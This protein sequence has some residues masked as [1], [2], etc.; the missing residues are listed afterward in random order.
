MKR[1]LTQHENETIFPKESP[2]E[3]RENPIEGTA[4]VLQNR[5]R[6]VGVIS[7]DRRSLQVSESQKVEAQSWVEAG[8]WLDVILVGMVLASVVGLTYNLLG[9]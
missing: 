8:I 6:P 7:T 2:W 1:V 5:C 9:R 3:Y 4:Y